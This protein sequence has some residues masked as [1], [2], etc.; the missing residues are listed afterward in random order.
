MSKKKSALLGMLLAA[1]LVVFAILAAT[2]GLGWFSDSTDVSATGMQVSAKGDLEIRAERGGENIAVSQ[3]SADMKHFGGEDVKELRPGAAGSFTFY[4]YDPNAETYDFSYTLSVV[5]NNFYDS[6]EGFYAGV[7]EERKTQALQMINA[8]LLLFKEKSDDGV[9]SGWIP[10]GEPMAVS[11]QER[12]QPV[13]VYWVWVAW[14]SDIFSDAGTLIAQEDRAKIADYYCFP[15]VYE[16]CCHRRTGDGGDRCKY[17]PDS[18]KQRLVCPDLGP[19][20]QQYK[21]KILFQHRPAGPGG[22]EKVY[23]RVRG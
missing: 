16:C 4:V 20:K 21:Y 23:A 19:A 11:A 14:Y 5:N 22:G 1:F 2:I 7:P 9:Y 10:A 8:H 6:E 12:E 15:C 17:R 13:T 18:R 3:P